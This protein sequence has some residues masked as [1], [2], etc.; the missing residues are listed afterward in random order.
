[1]LK[2]LAM[3]V[4]AIGLTLPAVVYGRT[5]AKPR[6][7]S[8]VRTEAQI[9]STVAACTVAVCKK[10]NIEIVSLS[11]DGRQILTT[12]TYRDAPHDV[13]RYIGQSCATYGRLSH[14]FDNLPQS[15]LIDQCNVLSGQDV[16]NN[17]RVKWTCAEECLY[18]FP[19]Q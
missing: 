1:M 6:V 15:Y 19:C 11:P 2:K 12:L 7:I 9:S 13:S 3:L 8:P 17:V 10:V 18:L 4:V 14:Y 16:C 5:I